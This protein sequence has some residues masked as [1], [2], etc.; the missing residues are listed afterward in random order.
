MQGSCLVNCARLDGHELSTEYGRPRVRLPSVT[1]T[2]S[3][4]VSYGLSS[5]MRIAIWTLLKLK[6]NA[7]QP[8]PAAASPPRADQA[9]AR[10]R[11]QSLTGCQQPLGYPAVIRF[12]VTMLCTT[13]PAG[14]CRRRRRGICRSPKT[15]AYPPDRQCRPDRE[16][17]QRSGRRPALELV[18]MRGDQYIR[19]EQEVWDQG[20]PIS[21]GRSFAAARGD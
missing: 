7:G 17:C 13:R 2:R 19:L 14:A 12:L 11:R 3:S 1:A 16:L 18:A 21:T 6:Q 20:T 8:R 5:R 15:A 9:L 10:R 4:T